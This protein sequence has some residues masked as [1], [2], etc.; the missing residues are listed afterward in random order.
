MSQGKKRRATTPPASSGSFISCPACGKDFPEAFVQNHAWRC[1]DSNSG[2]SINHV[3]PRTIKQRPRP[4]G[5][6]ECPTCGESFAQH[7]IHDHAWHCTTN[8]SGGISGNAVP[9]S[10]NDK[11]R[12]SR[13]SREPVR[14][15]C[16]RYS[17]SVAAGL[18]VG[19]VGTASSSYEISASRDENSCKVREDGGVGF[20]SSGQASAE[21][22]LR[23]S[24]EHS[25]GGDI[26]R[27]NAIQASKNCGPSYLEQLE[28]YPNPGPPCSWCGAAETRRCPMLKLVACGP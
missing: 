22:L 15:S 7:F 12:P 6:V 17:S 28:Q 3:T 9:L 4:S 5:F 18:S 19:A 24:Q 25:E 21:F 11:K 26:S 2:T 27:V 8:T 20:R 13:T 23:R 14:S 16:A 10:E 1:L